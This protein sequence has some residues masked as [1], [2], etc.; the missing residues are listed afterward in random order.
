M[1]HQEATTVV[2]R[3]LDR[4]EAA[5]ARIESWPQF[6]KGVV[7]VT[8]MGHERYTFRIEDGAERREVLL[9]IHHDRGAHTF[10]WKSLGGPVYRGHV[11]LH[12][13]DD[14]HTAVELALE[15]H[16]VGMVAGFAEMVA[17]RR[18]RATV[19]VQ[20]LERSLETAR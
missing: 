12:A 8:R 5:L 20:A 13:V 19:D 11:R 18:S 16:P 2:A 10:N 15:A 1:H 9:C 4:V 3:P 6:L 14:G 17:P 7:D